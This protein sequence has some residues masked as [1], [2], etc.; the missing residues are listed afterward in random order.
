MARCGKLPPT[1]DEDEQVAG[2]LNDIP[3]SPN[4][5]NKSILRRSLLK[6][7]YGVFMVT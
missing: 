5:M 4:A 3:L 6:C 7:T 1:V 2:D